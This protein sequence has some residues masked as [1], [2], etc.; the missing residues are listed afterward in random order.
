MPSHSV[1]A[2]GGDVGPSIFAEGPWHLG[3]P[4]LGLSYPSRRRNERGSSANAQ[5]V[6]QNALHTCNGVR[7]SHYG[8]HR[9]TDAW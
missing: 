5:H 9:R 7:E 3:G 2:G 8:R 1:H 4:Y 6:T